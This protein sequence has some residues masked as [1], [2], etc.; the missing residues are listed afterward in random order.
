L[1]VTRARS[2]S[3]VDEPVANRVPPAVANRPT[4]YVLVETGVTH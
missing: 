3:G 1:A 4:L 2:Q